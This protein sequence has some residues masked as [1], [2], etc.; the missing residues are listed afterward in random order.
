MLPLATHKLYL[1]TI[2]CF[3]SN[4]ST[5]ILMFC[6]LFWGLPKS[7]FPITIYMK[8]FVIN[9][10]H[11]ASLLILLLVFVGTCTLSYWFMGSLITIEKPTK[12]FWKRT[13]ALYSKVIQEYKYLNSVFIFLFFF[14]NFH[15]E[16]SVQVSISKISLNP[17]K[18]STRRFCIGRF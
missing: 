13:S 10:A 18:N 1:N 3:D 12:I 8:S 9:R 17:T 5:K 4:I 16:V 14:F 11:L 7:Y 6:C 2:Q 15:P